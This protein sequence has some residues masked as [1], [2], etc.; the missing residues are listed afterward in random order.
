MRRLS[1]IGKLLLFDTFGD[2]A[3]SS[4]VICTVSG[5]FLAIPYDVG[6]PYYSVSSMMIF[7]GP[8]MFIRNLH[9]WSAQLF[10]VFTLAH[11]FDHFIRKT[12]RKLKRYQ[13]ILLI[14]TIGVSFYAMLSG[15]ILK[16]D[17]DGMQAHRILSSLLT[18]IPRI[19]EEL[20]YS[21]L[22]SETDL[23]LVY[24]HHM[25]TATV[26]I[27]IM[28]YNHAKRVFPGY[29][30]FFI[31]LFITLLF[32]FLLQAPLHDGYSQVM[33]GPW[34]FLGLQ[35][36]LHWMA[37]PG[38]IWLIVLAVIAIMIA[39]RE[40]GP[41]SSARLKIIITGLTLVYLMLIA[42]GAFFRGE[43][44]EWKYR[45][46]G[47]LT[48]PS[49]LQFDPFAFFNDEGAGEN[50]GLTLVNGR[51]EGCLVCHSGMHGLTLSHSAEAAGCSSCHGGNPFT[52]SIR[53]AHRGMI[54]VPGNL[55]D[56]RRS[57]GT[58]QCHPDIPARVERSIMTTAS[59]LVSVDRYVFGARD[60][61]SYLSNIRDLGH[62]AADQHL[63]D[64][65]ANCHLG[66]PKEEP[67]P[68]N[69]LSK[70]GGC[71]ACHLNYSPEA[72]SE[73][74][75]YKASP[76][77][78]NLKF[79]PSLDLKITDDHCFGC[80]SRSGRISLSYTGLHETLLD[81][82]EME[83]GHVLLEDKRVAEFVVDDVHH[84]AGMLCID[85]H[86]ATELMGD[87][88]I[89]RHK[90]EQT[91]ISCQDCHPGKATEWA[92]FTSLDRESGKIA[93]LRYEQPENLQFLAAGENDLFYLNVHKTDTGGMYLFGK[94]DGKALRLKAPAEICTMGSS[95]KHLSC[96]SCHSAWVP[97]CIGCH[98]EFDPGAEGM[99]LLE[100][101][102]KMG[103][104]VEYVSR[105][106]HDRP[107]L[108]VKEGHNGKAREIG[109]FT[110]G[111]IITVALDSYPGEKKESLKLFHRLYAPASA[112]TTMAGGRSC[113]SCHLDPLA[114][115][116]GRGELIFH[117]ESG[118][119]E[120]KSRFAANP[121]DGLAE[122][123]WTG[124]LIY[125]DD[126]SATRYGMRPFNLVEQKAILTV[127][128][129]LTCH[130][131]DS[132]VMKSSLLDFNDVVN[133]KSDKCITPVWK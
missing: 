115:G 74:Y 25:A 121:N 113:E 89:Y 62:N 40:A 86:Q 19:G 68:V 70:G 52:T 111:M 31:L 110:P 37:R 81:S 36:I 66:M 22:G 71:N 107:V 14:F 46:V 72:K 94:A 44:W 77:G 43:N 133:R 26:I 98:N 7:N 42:I 56:A 73:L 21:L 122:D 106:M 58:S 16:G 55:A 79:H 38:L 5:V 32:S 67:E 95:H 6:D 24:V 47:P 131:G 130:P 41:V 57:C 88:N 39:I 114:I 123:A 34:Y 97:Q 125:R 75:K 13:W 109:T 99:D 119:W 60:S 87:G 120:L 4:L 45:S 50:M 33:K 128:A 9:Y 92:Y 29:F 65:C 80:H 61:L 28:T 17:P 93:R 3:S 78:Y 108:G 116:Y 12:E 2:M 124:F 20:K 126:Q 117:K 48:Q 118:T 129:C 15:F 69:M 112:H 76:Q 127:G 35:E 30:R 51:S 59:G 54:L 132:E 100:M 8:V 10:L 64:L 27:V 82:T 102:E 84:A 63:R 101:K 23:H 18:A 1:T 49:L 83:E 104:W 11:F 85:C 91:K 105:F 103:S 90:E 53:S 96:E